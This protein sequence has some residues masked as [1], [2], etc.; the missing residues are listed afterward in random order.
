MTPS[1]PTSSTPRCCWPTRGRCSASPSTRSCIP[2]VVLTELEGKRHHPEL[3]WAA[4][5]ALR[6]ARGPARSTTGRCCEP[7]PVNDE[8]GTLRVELNH[9]DTAGLP[10]RAAAADTNDHRILAVARNLANEGRDVVVVTKDLPLRLKASIVGLDGRR[11]PQRA[12]H[13]Q[14]AGPASSSSTST[15]ADI[16]ELFDRARRRPRRGARPAVPHRPGAAR[17]LAVGARPRARRQAGPPRA[18]RPRRCSTCAAARAE[19]RIAIDLLADPEVGI[20]Q[21]RRAAPAPARACSR[22]PPGSTPCSSS[23]PTSGSSCSGRSSPSAARSSATCPGTESREDVAVGRGGAPTPSRR[24]PAREVID[25]V[26][27]RGPARGPAAHP[28]P[29][30]Q[31]HR[32]L[33]RSSTRPR[34]SSARCCSPRCPGSAQGSRVVL[35]HDVAQRDNLRVGRHDGIV[36]V[37]EA[38]RGPP[39]VRPRHP[40]PL[41]AQRRRRP[42]HRAARRHRSPLT[43]R[44]RGHRNL[45]PVLIRAR[46]RPRKEANRALARRLCTQLATLCA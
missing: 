5:E 16:D 30:P 11:V 4:R 27:E 9:Q 18:R 33:R 23:A 46:P 2:L 41:R 6:H 1:A 34:T 21:P 14:R 32:Q 20:V 13:R 40:D 36:S 17:R 22:W 42:R 43:A 38:L 29:G 39:A 37:I 35:T 12:G 31:P 28:H 7:M 44:P 25:E 45:A 19:Q 8:G 15:R 26:L 24:S 10:G 3:G